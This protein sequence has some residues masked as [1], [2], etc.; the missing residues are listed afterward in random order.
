VSTIVGVRR[1]VIVGLAL[2]GLACGDA[3]TAPG[4]DEIFVVSLTGVAADDAG[5]VLRLTGGVE[6]AS[7]AHPSLDVAWVNDDAGATTVAILGPLSQTADVLVVRAQVNKGPLRVELREVASANGAV[8]F[9]SSVRALV[10]SG[11]GE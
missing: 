4:G 10:R 11:R 7:P 8:S 1:L 5:I 6:L 9:P 3:S 2:L